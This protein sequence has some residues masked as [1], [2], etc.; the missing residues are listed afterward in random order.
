V[1]KIQVW[2]KS[3]KNSMNVLDDL[4]TFLLLLRSLRIKSYQDARSSV[5]LSARSGV[6]P[7]KQ[8]M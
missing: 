4:S 8:F 7:A 1:K 6:A 3:V 2:L 5:I